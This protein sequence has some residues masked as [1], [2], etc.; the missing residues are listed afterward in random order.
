[1]PWSSPIWV[2]TMHS[3]LTITWKLQLVQNI[4]AH[5]VMGAP[6]FAYVTPLLHEALHIQ[7]GT[8]ERCPAPFQVQFKVLLITFKAL[9]DTGPGYMWDCLS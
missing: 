5:M 4:V 7:R 1:M 8:Y 9:Y 3:T 2:T 6:G